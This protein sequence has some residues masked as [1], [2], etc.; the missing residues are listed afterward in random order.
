MDLS[1]L[2]QPLTKAFPSLK[3][4]LNHPLAPYT[5][6]K[7]GGPAD[8]F[9]QTSSNDELI[10]VLNLIGEEKI[11][12]TI[13]GNGSNVLISDAGIRGIVIKNSDSSIKFND[14]HTVTVAS[15]TPLPLLI[16]QT[17]NHSLTGLEEFSY[18]PAS[19]GGA[20]WSNI[21]GVNKSNFDKFIVSVEM[22]DLGR[23]K[24]FFSPQRKIQLPQDPEGSADCKN[25]FASPK[26][27]NHDNLKWDYDF[28]EFQNHPEWLILSITLS[29][30]QGNSNTSKQLVSDIIAKKSVTQSMNSLGCVFKNP[31][32]DSAGRII[33]QELGLKGHA[34]GDAQVSDKH[35]NFIVNNGSATA[36]DYLSLVRLIQSQ[37]KS[38][39]GI[40]LEPEIKLLGE[41]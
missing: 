37:A 4:Y 5:T 13:L 11:P 28:S 35:A 10:K 25:S 26:T 14:N 22:L 3:A 30:S 17:I 12:I 1:L 24:Q 29:L 27:I 41:F 36:T 8:L 33:D 40:N 15:G 20:V 18:I 34:I 2:H 19:T 7:I 32:N 6:V 39:L 16:N 23:S 9:I 31:A 21:H 38:K